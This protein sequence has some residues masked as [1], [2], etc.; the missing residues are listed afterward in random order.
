MNL[1]NLEALATEHRRSL[2]LLLQAMIRVGRPF[3][4]PTDVDALWREFAETAAGEPLVGTAIE[5]VLR[6]T[7]E[8]AVSAPWVL[9][10]VRPRVAGNRYLRLHAEDVLVDEV[11]PSDFLRFKER[12]VE[13]DRPADEWM[14]ELDLKPFGRGL[15]RMTEP[16]SIG[17]GVEFLNRALSSRLFRGSDGTG[18]RALLEF[19]RV[20]QHDGRPLMLD[21]RVTDVPGLRAA[22]TKA[23]DHLADLDDAQGWNEAGPGLEALGFLRGWGNNVGRIRD[24]LSLL[25]DILEASSPQALETFLARVPM[26]FRVAILSPHGFFG[27]SGVLGLPDT[28]GQVVYIL[29]QVRALER[30]MRRQIAEQGLDIEPDILVVTRLIPE[31]RGSTCDQRLEPIVGTRNARIL[32]IPFRCADGGVV[33]HWISRFEIY[34]YLERFALEVEA[35]LLREMHD[36]P[37][38][39]VGNYTDGNLVAWLLSQRLGVTQCNIA[40]ALEKL[41]YLFSALYW[42]AN[43]ERYHFSCQ[44]TADLIAM[45]GADF[46]ISS[47][48]QEIAGA[49]RGVGQYESYRTFTMP[50]LYRVTEGIDVFDPKF[51]IVSPGADDTVFFPWRDQD[52]RLVE[53]HPEIERLVLGGPDDGSRGRLDRPELPLL[54]SMARLDHIKNLTGLVSWYAE[55][56]ALQERANLLIIAGAVHVEH[57]DDEE[58]RHQIGVMHELMD[59]H[60]LDGKVRWIGA[61]LDKNLSG[62]L[63]RWVADR[64]GAFVQPALFEAFGLTVIEAMA[65]GLPTFATRFGG[66]LEIIED[67][68]SGFHVDPT[69]GD[70]AAAR[71]ADF[72][73]RC[74]DDPA[75]W[76]LVAE[77]GIARVEE[78][79]T[80][81]LY[82]RRM[83]TLSRIY[84]FWKFITKPEREE[85]SRYLEMF[86]NL[87]F[88][89]LA[90]NVGQ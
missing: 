11:S 48:Y 57:S 44:F 43:E 69:R 39:I 67:G 42:K 75:A 23:L 51:N 28:G 66:P 87:M 80:W 29:N 58:E 85:T 38:L 77:A 56:P 14:L 31:A 49:G 78:R 62:E 65:S 36:R 47:T 22:I 72:L 54:F 73:A 4:L 79:Y 9:L 8:C 19:L 41:K 84:G 60:G 53:L 5:G 61:R 90:R 37:D 63:Y 21:G 16:R 32:R 86:Y 68:K 17:R 76:D 59:R 20:H 26:I 6:D 52:R 33:P 13:P 74:A 27:Q 35:E 55:S 50:G 83:L 2:Y 70:E 25:L 34:P 64:R 1:E 46:V 88:K 89:P 71:M 18:P 82:A 40:H 12:L 24:T 81:G 3:L 30:E 45:N 10:D 15:P 7:Q